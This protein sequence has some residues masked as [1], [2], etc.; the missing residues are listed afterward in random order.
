MNHCIDDIEDLVLRTKRSAEA[1]KKLQK[2]KGKAKR[3]FASCFDPL[4]KI[5]CFFFCPINVMYLFLNPCTFFIPTENQLT[6]EARPP[7]EADF[8]DAFQKLKHALNLLVGFAWDII[9]TH[10][11]FVLPAY[12]TF[13]CP[14]H[15]CIS[16]SVICVTADIKGKNRK[17]TIQ[18]HKLFK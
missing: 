17:E 1:W 4:S 14:L 3:E 15:M 11:C 5:N 12:R 6:Q 16:S 10:D 8:Y 9:H 18:P 13:L 2:K 7:P